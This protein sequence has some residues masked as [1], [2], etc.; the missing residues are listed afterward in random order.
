MSTTITTN[1]ADVLA[2]VS[3][4]LSHNKGL[5]IGEHHWE[6][7]AATFLIGH[8]EKL[9]QQGVTTLYI[10]QDMYSAAASQAGPECLQ[11]FIYENNI[12]TPKSLAAKDLYDAVAINA[13]LAGLRVIGHDDITSR[14]VWN[15]RK[16]K[17]P[18]ITTG[19]SLDRRDD[20]GKAV[21]DATYDGKKYIVLGGYFHSGNEVAAKRPSGIG[22]DQR[23]D[24]P[25]I[26][27]LLGDN[28]RINNPEVAQPLRAQGFISMAP[29]NGSA[30]YTV[31]ANNASAFTAESKSYADGEVE[32]KYA[33]I[34]AQAKRSGACSLQPLLGTKELL[35]DEDVQA[36]PIRLKRTAEGLNP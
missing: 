12:P 20:F 19:E 2:L 4:L 22:L 14:L 32:T 30:T 21:I 23:L 35:T 1:P 7:L 26:D 10:E 18:L 15:A 9:K 8:F 29:G 17:M 25:S 27:F 28:D 5:F 24:I 31:R 36:L 16:E 6:P 11:S 34:L 3:Q 33:A 13:R